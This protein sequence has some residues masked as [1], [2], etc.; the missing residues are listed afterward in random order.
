VCLTGDGVVLLS[1]DGERWEF[2]AGR[3]EMQES[4]L[5]TLRREMREEACCKVEAAEAL[6][7]TISTCFQGSE[8][9][10]VRAHWAVHVVAM[11]WRPHH[12]ITHRLEVPVDAVMARLT[13]EPGLEAVYDVVWGAAR[14]SLGH[15]GS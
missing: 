6:G 15:E 14:R 3:P 5:D 4:L 11:P 2:P 7:F 1:R 12:E 9:G 10:L 13:V 8:D